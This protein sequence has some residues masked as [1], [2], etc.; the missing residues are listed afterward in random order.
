MPP[1]KQFLFV[2][3][4]DRAIGSASTTDFHVVLQQPIRHVVK[5]E[6]VDI[7]I[8]YQLSNITSGDNSIQF[9]LPAALQSAVGYRSVELD[10]NPYTQ[11]ELAVKLEEFLGGQDGQFDVLLLNGKKLQVN[12]WFPD[13]SQYSPF[14]PWLVDPH[15][16]NL[17]CP[18]SKL[19]GQL[20]LTDEYTSLVTPPTF[21]C[22]QLCP[23]AGC[24]DGERTTCLQACL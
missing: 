21:H 2:S 8:Q 19:R 24:G 17:W 13:H 1:R 3:S 20:G 18:S 11:K 15:L 16:Y 9:Q 4:D 7:G 5:T 22:G 12:L 6:V 10:E 23:G 14:T